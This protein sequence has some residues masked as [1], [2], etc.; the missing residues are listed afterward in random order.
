M[1]DIR[2]K[3]RKFMGC[4]NIGILKSFLPDAPGKR[5]YV[6]RNNIE[7]FCQSIFWRLSES[8]IIFTGIIFSAWNDMGVGQSRNNF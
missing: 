8:E 5:G 2:L 6:A 1:A 4:L 3:I 7:I